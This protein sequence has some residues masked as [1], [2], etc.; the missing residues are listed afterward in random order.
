MNRFAPSEDPRK[1]INSSIERRTSKTANIAD[2]CPGRGLGQF[3]GGAD[4]RKGE[5]KYP[6]LAERACYVATSNTLGCIGYRGRQTPQHTTARHCTEMDSQSVHTAI[7]CT[8]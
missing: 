4:E 7:R 6:R 5:G 3:V 1:Q 2:I 8:M